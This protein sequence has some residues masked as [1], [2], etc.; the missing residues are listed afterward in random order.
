MVDLDKLRHIC[1]F[2]LENQQVTSIKVCIH[3]SHLIS[4]CSRDSI[5]VYR[6]QEYTLKPLEAVK[7][8]GNRHFTV[9]MWNEGGLFVGT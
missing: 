5:R 8:V 6:L 7:G 1:Y 9:Q 4:L 2:N 3:D